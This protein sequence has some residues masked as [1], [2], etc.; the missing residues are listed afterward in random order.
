[1]N[2]IQIDIVRGFNGGFESGKRSHV[3]F[4]AWTIITI[5][6]FVQCALC[7]SCQVIDILFRGNNEGLLNYNEYRIQHCRLQLIH[8]NLT[9]LDR[10]KMNI[11]WRSLKFVGT[12]ESF[13][14]CIEPHIWLNYCQQAN[15]KCAQTAH[16]DTA[17]Q[18]QISLC[19]NTFYPKTQKWIF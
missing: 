8:S 11:V 16:R 2:Q 10:M 15:S 5:D 9:S 19:K 4:I 13:S 18:T 3:T 17:I 6:T 12:I 14:L 1:M 7:V